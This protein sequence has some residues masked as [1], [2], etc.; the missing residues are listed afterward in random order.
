MFFFLFKIIGLLGHFR[1]FIEI[2]GGPSRV[3]SISFKRWFIYFID[4]HSRVS[5][6]YL[7]RD[8]SEVP[9]IFENFYAM[10][11]TQYDTNIQIIR[12]DNGTKYFNSILGN[13]LL[14]KGI[15]HQSSCVQTP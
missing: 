1:L 3:T 11:H 7:L 9:Q 5:W 4:D 13:F 14:K 8:K 15:L 2:C 12:T 6:V 10:I